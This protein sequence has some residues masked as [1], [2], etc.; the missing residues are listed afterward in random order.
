LFVRLG[1]ESKVL[2]DPNE[3]SKDGALTIMET[4]RSKDG[5]IYAYGL[6]SKG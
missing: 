3:L 4:S 5:G 2:I 6:S 1:G